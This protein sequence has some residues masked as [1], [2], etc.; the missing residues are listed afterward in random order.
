MVKFYVSTW[1]GYGAQWLGQ[2][3]IQVWLWKYCTDVINIYNQR[4][5]QIM[6]VGLI[7]T[8]ALRAQTKFPGQKGILLVDGSKESSVRFQTSGLP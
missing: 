6:W 5:E 2:T 3:L 8:K 4:E 7:Q 1:W